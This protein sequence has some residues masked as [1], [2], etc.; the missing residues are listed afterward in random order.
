VAVER[1]AGDSGGW[2]R[3]TV[4]VGCDGQCRLALAAGGERERERER[5]REL[6]REIGRT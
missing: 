6:S 1:V 4:A 2:R 3:W 5:E